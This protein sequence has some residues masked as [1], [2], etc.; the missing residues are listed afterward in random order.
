MIDPQT[1]QYPPAQTVVSSL[2]YLPFG[3][4]SSLTYGDGAVQTRE[5]DSSYRLTRQLDQLGATALRD[6]SYGWTTRANLA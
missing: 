6:T 5:F 3:P 2:Q 4:L 1:G